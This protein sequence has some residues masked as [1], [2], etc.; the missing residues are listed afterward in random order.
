MEP[1]QLSG[2]NFLNS[3]KLLEIDFSLEKR[4]RSVTNPF[5]DFERGEPETFSEQQS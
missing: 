3:L 5:H 1:E 2:A 4:G